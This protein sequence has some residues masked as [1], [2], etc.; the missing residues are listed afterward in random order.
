MTMKGERGGG[1]TQHNKLQL[2]LFYY[3][4]GGGG[5]AG[6][7]ESPPVVFPLGRCQDRYDK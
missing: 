2:D 4:S 1:E 7:A 5:G 6:A 3:G